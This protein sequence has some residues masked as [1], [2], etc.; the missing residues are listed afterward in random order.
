MSKKRTTLIGLSKRSPL[1]TGNRLFGRHKNSSHRNTKSKKSGLI[2]QNLKI[3]FT[4]AH[5]V[6]LFWENPQSGNLYPVVLNGRGEPRNIG[7]LGIKDLEK[8]TVWAPEK[9][10][11]GRKGIKIHKALG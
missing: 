5:C 7:G 10:G 6:G 8:G 3:A 1:R 4:K 11:S 2:E 9:S